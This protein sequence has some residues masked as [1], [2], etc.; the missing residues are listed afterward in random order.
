[1]EYPKMQAV[2]DEAYKKFEPDMGLKDFY[3][4]LTDKETSAVLLGNLNYQVENGGFIQWYDNGYRVGS[5]TLLNVL[6]KLGTAEAKKV[7]GLVRQCLR[8]MRTVGSEEDFPDLSSLDDDFYSVADKL[9][10]QVEATL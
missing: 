2:M 8:E 1:M 3:S 4:T 7:A 6:E 9:L 5:E 10:A